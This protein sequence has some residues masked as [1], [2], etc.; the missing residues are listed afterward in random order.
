MKISH[1]IIQEDEIQMIRNL[2]YKKIETIKSRRR[3]TKNHPNTM[4]NLANSDQDEIQVYFQR[5]FAE[6]KSY[7]LFL[8]NEYLW[9]YIPCS[10][11]R[12]L[13]IS[14]H[15]PTELAFFPRY[16]GLKSP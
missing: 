10:L 16:K 2:R 1:R 6:L 5:K 11:C 14:F 9:S 8:A 3:H 4:R 15:E 12:G 13:K 7:I